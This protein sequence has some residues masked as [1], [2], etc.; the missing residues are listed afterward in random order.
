MEV[1]S[2]K[3]FV[4][5]ILGIISLIADI[6]AIKQ[7]IQDTDLFSFS[8]FQNE[9]FSFSWIISIVFI[10]LLSCMSLGFL[11]YGSSESVKKNYYLFLVH[12]I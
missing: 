6:I 12:F 8:S 10:V 2:E 1:K 7:F 3:A 11:I 9:L 5:I 4:A